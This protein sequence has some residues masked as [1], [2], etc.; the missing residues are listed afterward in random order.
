MGSFR[1]FSSARST[2]D[3]GREMDVTRVALKSW[4]IVLLS[5]MTLLF[6]LELAFAASKPFEIFDRR[7][8]KIIMCKENSLKEWQPG[9]VSVKTK[10]FLTYKKIIQQMN[11]TLRESPTPLPDVEAQLKK[12]TKNLPAYQ[13]LCAK[14]AQSIPDPRSTPKVDKTAKPSTTPKKTATPKGSTT[15]KAGSTPTARPTATKS[16]G[17]GGNAALGAQAWQSK[18]ANC[19]ISGS[20]NGRSAA[21]ISAAFS[22][23][24][25]MKP[26][27]S[28]VSSQEITN[29]AAYLGGD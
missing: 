25:E 7:S 23:V 5:A 26:F 12:I 2:S 19:H 9:E 11:K 17:S 15:P 6:C 24:P 4:S 1:R 8:K 29:I 10:K 18:C 14:A 13:R 16:S 20:K 21:Q 28:I 27:K 3:L 22:S